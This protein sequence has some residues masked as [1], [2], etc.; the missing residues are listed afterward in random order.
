MLTDNFWTKAMERYPNHSAR[1]QRG[2]TILQEHLKNPRGGLIT[3]V[4]AFGGW[5]FTVKSQTAHRAYNVTAEGCTC[6]DWRKSHRCKH[7]VAASVL[8]QLMGAKMAQLSPQL[9]L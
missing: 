7:F 3:P 6:P 5:T 2:R 4:V 1:I 8:A 9:P